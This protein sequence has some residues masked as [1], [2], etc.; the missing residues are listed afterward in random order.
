[1]A[2]EVVRRAINSPVAFFAVSCELYREVCRAHEVTGFPMV[3]GWPR[4]RNI[5]EKGILLEKYRQPFTVDVVASRLRLKL[6]HEAKPIASNTTNE[7]EQAELAKDA[8][9]RK[10]ECFM[11]HSTLNDRY[12]D[13]ATSLAFLLKSSIFLGSSDTLNDRRA[14]ALQEFLEWT[15]WAVPQDWHVRTGLIQDV[16]GHIV[17]LVDGRGGARTLIDLV[18]VHQSRHFHFNV[19]GDLVPREHTGHIIG[20]GVD[21]PHHKVASNHT[22]KE[23]LLKNIQW[24]EACSHKVI[25]SGYTCGLWELFHILTIGSSLQD[26]RWFAFR[27]GYSTAPMELAQVLK[28][29]VNQFLACDVCRWNFVN[30]YDRCTHDRCKRLVDDMPELHEPVEN[31]SEDDVG[32]ELA[33]WLWEVHNSVNVRLMRE[34]A[35]EEDRNVTKDEQLAAVFPPPSLCPKCWHDD[36]LRV[37]DKNEVYAFLKRWYWP[38]SESRNVAFQRAI[39]QRPA[40]FVSHARLLRSKVEAW[41]FVVGP[42][43]IVAA[44]ILWRVLDKKADLARKNV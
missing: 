16:L 27:R 28:R 24:T 41:W 30:A 14:L 36:T 29:A 31:T 20:L 11:T 42:L 40:V 7:K 39:H 38:P 15:Y 18:E 8:A 34:S 4:W 3:M 21:V 12:H 2:Q 25:G 9:E 37:Y 5:Q 10:R 23:A 22:S 17:S 32:K 35:S 43:G 19:W 6:A 33:I 44:A 13:A 26:H 1:V